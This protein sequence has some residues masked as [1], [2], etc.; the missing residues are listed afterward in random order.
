MF[1]L[2]LEYVRKNKW[3]Y[4]LVAVTL[5]LYDA[6]LVIPTQVVLRLVDA[7]GSHHLTEK[8]LLLT[9]GFLILST[10]VN[11]G[12]AFIWHLNLFQQSIHF[13]F[14]MQQR[15]FYK[16]V[17]MQTP[18]YE[19]FRSG[20][21]MTRFSTDVEMLQEMVGYGLMIILYAGGMIAFIIP[22]MFMISWQ[23]ALLGMIPIVIMTYGTYRV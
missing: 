6:T 4:L 1:K 23:I 14:D 3:V 7:I 17:T 16:L 11:Y 20:D 18:F 13:I 22:V 19:K 15:A 5:I 10:L 2:V 8:G 12:T 9:V 21:M